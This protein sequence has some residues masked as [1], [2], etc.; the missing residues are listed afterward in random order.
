MMKK[1]LFLLCLLPFS[2]V[3]QK[4]W[5]LNDCIAYAKEHNLS[6]KQSEID[7][8][9]TDIEVW[10]TKAN[11]L[12]SINSEAAYNWNTGKNIRSGPGWRRPG[13]CGP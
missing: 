1:T 8:K 4:L 3:A 13:H 2:A 5:T 7:L 6:I 11:F 9:S 12:P 10:Q